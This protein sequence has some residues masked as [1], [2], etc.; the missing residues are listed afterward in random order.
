[1]FNKKE[2]NKCRKKIS[3][4]YSFC[5]HCGAPLEAD[6]ESRDWGMLGKNDFLPSMNELNLPFGLNAM[7]NSLMKN[8]TKQFNE[9][10][11]DQKNFGEQVK[12]GGIRINI[13]RS[14]NQQPII[15]MEHSG[16]GRKPKKILPG[17]FSEKKL[18]EFSSLPRKEPKT[19]IRRLSRKVIYVIDIPGVNSI[20]NISITKLETSLEIRAIAKDKAYF[21]NIP[22][23]LPIIDYDLSEEKLVLEFAVK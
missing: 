11:K 16:T 18:K 7:F 22:I 5:P 12:T 14:G 6:F 17:M 2:C 20:E 10:E 19:N 3:E 8:M 21:K 1:M 4:K 13:S 15:R 9:I 23:N